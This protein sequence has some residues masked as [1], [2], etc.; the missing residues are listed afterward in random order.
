MT[1][2]KHR[3]ASLQQQSYLSEAKND[4]FRHVLQHGQIHQ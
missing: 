1:A 3:T 2:T 4:V